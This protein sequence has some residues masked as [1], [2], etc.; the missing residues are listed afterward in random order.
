[1]DFLIEIHPE[2]GFRV[3]LGNPDLDFENLNPDFPIERT[4]IKYFILAGK[5]DIHG[6]SENTVVVA[7]KSDQ[8]LGILSH[9]DRQRYL[10]AS[11]EI[12]ELTFSV[13]KKCIEHD[14]FRGVY[15]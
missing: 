2:D 7:K 10:P 9:S 12:S 3:R 5:C 8:M 1:M 6:F 4:P 13:E 14:A 11:T 15:F